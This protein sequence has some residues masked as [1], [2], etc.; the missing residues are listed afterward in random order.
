MAN[1]VSRSVLEVLL[2]RVQQGVAAV[3]ADGRIAYVNQR[4]ASLLGAGR[5]ALVGRPLVELAAEPARAA[6][7]DAL[8]AG[9]DTASQCRV[10]MPR[11]GQG[12]LQ[13]FITFAPLG[14]GQVSCMV[15][16]VGQVKNGGAMAHELR[17]LLTAMRDSTDRLKRAGLDADGRHALEAIERQGDRILDLAEDLR[18]VN[19]REPGPTP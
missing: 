9:H 11:P 16:D 1:A 18:R 15:T 10:A 6:L 8:S 7:S 14:H 19:P 3:T 5:A 2:D 4:F 13:A 12:E 17:T